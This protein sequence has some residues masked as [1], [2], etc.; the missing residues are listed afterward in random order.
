MH[1]QLQAVEV[2][3]YGTA[4]LRLLQFLLVERPASDN[5]VYIERQ[6]ASHLTRKF[7][8][9]CTRGKPLNLCGRGP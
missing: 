2:R 6:I 7:F 9:R 4:L 5:S 1:T 8:D 3:L